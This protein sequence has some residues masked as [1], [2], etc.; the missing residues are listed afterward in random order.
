MLAR[1]TSF[2]KA[3]IIIGYVF[4]LFLLGA[5][6][7]VTFAVISCWRNGHTPAGVPMETAG[8]IGGSIL[9]VMFWCYAA[10]VLTISHLVRTANSFR[11]CRILSGVLLVF[12][13]F[14]TIFGLLTRMY[15][16]GHE[17]HRMNSR[18]FNE[19]IT[20]TADVERG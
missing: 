18:S 7:A 3:L 15:L 10:L 13:P 1:H 12:I 19:C 17:T 2:G 6:V 11:L 4:G 5:A 14:G 20:P 9:I 16:N 8:R